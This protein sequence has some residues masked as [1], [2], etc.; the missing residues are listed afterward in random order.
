MSTV[1]LDDKYLEEIDKTGF[2]P[3]FILGLE[4]SGTSI[5]YKLLV[6]TGCFNFLDVYHI[7]KYPELLHNYFNKLEK[8]TR[9]ELE[10]FF[11]VNLGVDRGIDRLRISS[12]FPEEYRF[13]LGKKTGMLT[14][15]PATLGLFVE[16]CKKIQF[17]SNNN[18][19]LLL[20]NPSDFTSFRYIKRVLPGSKFIFIHR[21]PVKTLDSQMRAMR[22]LLKNK[23]KY[24]AAISPG[25][26]KI[27]EKKI[28]LA[29]YKLI[30]FYLT[31]LMLFFH[32]RKMSKSLSYFF[33]N[34]KHLKTEDF[35]MTTYEKLCEK[36]DEEIGDILRFLNVS[37][38]KNVDLSVFIKTRAAKPLREIRF[39]KKI[40]LMCTKKYLRFLSEI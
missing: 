13:I 22:E 17:I 5:L 11:K 3:V 35:F 1:E 6:E 34:I 19:P 29:Y 15:N 40:V 12:D 20:K 31:P 39:F 10:E 36:P 24:M 26:R 32:L 16:M 25:Y 7:I 8:K 21:N 30:Y 37:C 9:M 38:E 14:V 18:K 28:L 27:F 23:S 33:K 4:R 2:F